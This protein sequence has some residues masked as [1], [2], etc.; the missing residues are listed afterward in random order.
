MPPPEDHKR[1]SIVVSA[2]AVPR[3]GG[4]GIN[5]FHMVNELREYFDVQLFC[6]DALAGV[7]TQVVPASP[8]S[9]WISK[10]PLLRRLRDIQNRWSDIHFDNYVAQRLPAANLFQGVGGQCYHSL[11]KAKKLGCR[12]VVD[13]IT[14]HID[15]FVEHQ[16][17]ECALFH[18]RPATDPKI[19]AR[20]REEYQ[21]ADL[22]R[23]LSEHARQTFLERGHR[24]VI[25]ARPRIDV[26]EFPEASFQQSKF[27]ISFVG[28]LEPWKGFHYL[29]DAFEA[30]DLPD[31]ELIF[32]GAAGTRSISQY[33]QEHLARNPRIQL[34]PIEVRSAYGEVYGKSSVLV[35]PSLSE[36]FGY[37]VAEAM[38]SGVPVIVT[39]NAGAADLVVDGQNGFVVPARDPEAIRDRLAH[40]A[41]HPAL[42]KKMG[43]AA[44]ETMRAR[45]GD[46]WRQYA[47]ALEQ[48]I[49]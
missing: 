8:L 17:R 40:L 16:K 26:S 47:A 9:T 36:G 15:D 37:V 31:S 35:H 48:L 2:N 6:R 22:I 19:Q 13:S 46:E 33:L 23:V 20:T 14:T 38:A 5:L 21:C 25:V 29:M 42:V 18:V 39:K 32:W 28:L 34:R 41:A 1:H 44:R 30:L 7:P 10:V 24:N 43:H 4:Q 45:N 11:G 27:R 49:A 12:T 3:R